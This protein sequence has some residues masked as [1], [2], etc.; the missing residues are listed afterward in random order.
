MDPKICLTECDQAISDGE[1]AVAREK[2]T[3][4]LIWRARDG[5]QPVDVANSGKRGDEFAAI[6]QAR[7]IDWK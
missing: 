2:L 7:I 1:L 3:D 4:Y 5:F 6:C